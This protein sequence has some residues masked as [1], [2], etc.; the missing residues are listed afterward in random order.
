[1]RWVG[2]DSAFLK[3]EASEGRDPLGRAH[4]RAEDARESR[5]VLAEAICVTFFLPRALRVTRLVNP[6]R[7]PLVR[8]TTRV[9][10]GLL[11]RP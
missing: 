1:V 5:D 6:H 10:P 11:D 7:A 9:A 8:N 4:P 3:R 2:V